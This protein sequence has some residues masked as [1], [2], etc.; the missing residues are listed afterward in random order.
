MPL[1]GEGTAAKDS[2]GKKRRTAPQTELARISAENYH[3]SGNSTCV[4]DRKFGPIMIRGVVTLLRRAFG[5][6][7]LLSLL[8]GGAEVA[9]RVVEVRNRQAISIKKPSPLRM[10]AVPSWTVR[11]ELR[12]LASVRVKTSADRPSHAVV[13]NS[14]GLR[15]EELEIPKPPDVYRVLCLGDESLLGLRLPEEDLLGSH[16]ERELQDATR[17]KVEVCLAGVPEAC[18]LTEF[19]L[20]THR[21][22]ALQ[23]DLV[24]VAVNERDVADD[25]AHRR[26]ARFDARGVPL[27]CRHS[28]LSRAA[29]TDPLTAWRQQFRLVDLGLEW[30]GDRWKR[31]TEF[32]AEFASDRP[33]FPGGASLADQPA[34][35]AL[36]RIARPD[37]E[38]VPTELHGVVRVPCDG[39]RHGGG[40]ICRIR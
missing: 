16:L 8:L 9:I 6:V 37:G 28:S 5:A 23:P 32:D 15:G 40:A 1:E 14:Y 4:T 25:L 19:L 36:S 11:Q 2:A 35:E 17:L 30:A 18:P 7:L 3:S 24:L 29:R 39:G 22:A 20:L 13:I 10:I 31:E 21:L 27:A 33:P 34:V 12:P 38:L 26:Y